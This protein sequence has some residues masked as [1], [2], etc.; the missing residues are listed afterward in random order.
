MSWLARGT[1]SDRPVGRGE[2]DAR[3]T[4]RSRRASCGQRLR[5]SALTSTSRASAAS[6][7][8][9]PMRKIASFTVVERTDAVGALGDDDERAAGFDERR[10]GGGDLRGLIERRGDRK[11]VG[12]D[13]ERRARR[14][15]GEPGARDARRL[16]ETPRRSIAGDGGVDATVGTDTPFEQERR[17]RG[18]ARRLPR[19]RRG[20]D[21]RRRFR[22]ARRARS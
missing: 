18:A 21:C 15:H 12:R 2:D 7:G 20:T 5:R 11:G 8:S 16:R 17:R 10:D 4:A 19:D 9:T 22:R 6:R 13:H 3:R 14:A 1:T